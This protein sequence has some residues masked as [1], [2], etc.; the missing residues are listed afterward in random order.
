MGLH[1]AKSSRTVTGVFGA[2]SSRIWGG[3][4]GGELAMGPRTNTITNLS[5]EPQGH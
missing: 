4:G 5:D 2:R 3:G 1:C